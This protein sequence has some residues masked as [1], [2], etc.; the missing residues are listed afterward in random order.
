MSGYIKTSQTTQ[1]LLFSA[2]TDPEYQSPFSPSGYDKTE[3]FGMVKKRIDH[4]ALR[5]VDLNITGSVM[6]QCVTKG[7]DLPDDSLHDVTHC[8][9]L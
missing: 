4:N 9:I 8:N 5:D 3:A 6:L 2:D 7:E 1:A